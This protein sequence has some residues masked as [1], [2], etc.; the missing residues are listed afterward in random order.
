[1]ANDERDNPGIRVPPP[2]IYL[3]PL[4]AGLL[5]DRRSHVACLP[6]GVS[7]SIGWSLIGGGLRVSGLFSR[8]IRDADAP[9]RT[10]K[11]VLKITTDGPFRY[12]RGRGPEEPPREDRSS[13]AGP[14]RPPKVLRWVGAG[15]VGCC[16]PEKRH[17]IYKR[18]RL[19]AVTNPDGVLEMMGALGEDTDFSVSETTSE[20]TLPLLSY[21]G[22]VTKPATW[23]AGN[24]FKGRGSRRSP[25][26]RV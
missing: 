6:R 7:P 1:M 11:P 10:D 24:L 14:R 5:L 18:L 26:R 21:N 23:S 20:V 4:F 15:E 16:L 12:T 19:K 9:V 2:L 25:G 22:L 3:L 8:T 17:R 13:K